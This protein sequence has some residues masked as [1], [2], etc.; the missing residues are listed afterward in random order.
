M[1]RKCDRCENEATVHEVVIRN[2]EKAEKHLCE[3]CAREGGVALGAT[4]PITDLI[5]KFVISQA[6]GEKPA[7]KSGACAE[8]G[9]T[10]AEFRQHG[11]LGCPECYTAFEPQLSSMIERAHEGATH[12]VG[13]TPKRAGGGA[14]SRHERIMRLRKELS[15]AIGSEQYERAAS[16]RDQLMHVEQADEGGERA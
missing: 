12:H 9:L 2:G 8:C 6:K 11:L 1:K 13:K 5:T 7:T 10:F 15:E 3:S 14:P 16:L 4:A